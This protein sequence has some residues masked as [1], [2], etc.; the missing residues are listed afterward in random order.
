MQTHVTKITASQCVD[1]LTDG[2]TL[3]DN[4]S[5][6]RASRK[7]CRG[8]RPLGCTVRRTTSFLPWF[9]IL[10]NVDGLM[11]LAIPLPRGAS[12][13]LPNLRQRLVLSSESGVGLGATPE[14][15]FS[16]PRQIP[17]SGCI[18]SAELN[19]DLPHGFSGHGHGDN[20][21]PTA[22][23]PLECGVVQVVVVS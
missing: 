21:H 3:E 20:M 23:K 18:M 14:P 4:D 5:Y 2:E 12:M 11:R 8:R 22:R 16:R 15:L 6:P 1:G 13:R 7:R 17:R 19:Y 10:Q 9:H